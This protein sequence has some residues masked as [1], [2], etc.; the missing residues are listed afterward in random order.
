VLPQAAGCERLGHQAS[1][2][3]TAGQRFGLSPAAASRG[4]IIDFSFA[5]GGRD[6]ALTF[7]LIDPGV[8]G[9]RMADPR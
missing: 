7:E 2:G 3:S 8:T 1:A 5:G 4:A 9:A 6:S